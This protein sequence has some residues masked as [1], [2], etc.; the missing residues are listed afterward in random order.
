MPTLRPSGDIAV[1]NLTVQQLEYLVAVAD[2]PTW[3]VAAAVVGVTPSAMSQGLAELERRVGISLF[4]RDGRRRVLAPTAAPVLAHA[5]EVV[6]RTVDLARYTYQLRE[7]RGGSLRVGMIDA[8]AV[9]HFSHL[10][11]HFRAERPDLD[12][13]LTVTSSAALLDQLRRAELDLVVC[14]EPPRFVDSTISRP[15]MSESL[16]VHAPDRRSLER[17]ARD[18]G[19]WVSFPSDSHTRSVIQRALRQIGAPFNVV[20]ESHQPEVLREMVRVGLGWTVLPAAARRSDT[21]NL[22][23]GPQI[24]L[25]QLIVA[26]R[27]DAV[28]N[29][30]GLA[31]EEALNRAVAD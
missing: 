29:P 8:A 16:L 15:L 14:V 26:R 6:A 10:L 25:R 9:I 5:R 11:R 20:A 4:E 21:A 3:A 24:A 1:P 28:A 13:R 18:W 30:A 27:S 19:P 31:L 22:A 23:V 17:P 7:G 2:A 12:L